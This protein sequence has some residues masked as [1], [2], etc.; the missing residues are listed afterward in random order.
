MLKSPSVKCKVPPADTV[1]VPSVKEVT[2]IESPASGS[3]SLF[4]TPLAAFTVRVVSSLVL[5]ESLLATGGWLGGSLQSR[6]DVPALSSFGKLVGVCPLVGLIW[7]SSLSYA[8]S[9]PSLSASFPE[10]VVFAVPSLLV[11]QPSSASLSP[12]S[13]ESKSK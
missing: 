3:L 1:V 10:G 12:S 8:S 2:E 13:S 9:K 4:N 11:S 5:L 6:S 7:L